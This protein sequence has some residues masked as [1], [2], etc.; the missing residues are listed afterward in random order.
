MRDGGIERRGGEF[1]LVVIVFIVKREVEE[2]VVVGDEGG[3][4]ENLH[5]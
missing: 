5:C 2:E 3:L 4:V 1:G